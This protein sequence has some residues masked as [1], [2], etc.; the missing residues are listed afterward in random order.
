[1]K[2]ATLHFLSGGSGPSNKQLLGICKTSLFSFGLCATVCCKA[3]VWLHQSANAGI[4]IGCGS[5]FLHFFFAISQTGVGVHTTESSYCLH[6]ISCS[7]PLF[8]LIYQ[9][10][11][12]IVCQFL[13]FTLS[14]SEFTVILIL[15]GGLSRLVALP[16][17][18]CY[19]YV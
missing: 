6:P 11:E 5:L 2:G 16:A 17:I 19:T 13:S 18:M 3:L 15:S 9:V 1:M 10:V 4:S 8:F 7:Y 14:S 12:F